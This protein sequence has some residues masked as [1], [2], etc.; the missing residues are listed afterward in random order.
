MQSDWWWLTQCH[1]MTACCSWY[2]PAVLHSLRASPYQQAQCWFASP[3]AHVALPHRYNRC[4]LQAEGAKGP[5]DI[6]ISE[7]YCQ[8]WELL[9]RSDRVQEHM[10]RFR[11]GGRYWSMVHTNVYRRWAVIDFKVDSKE[12]TAEPCKLRVRAHLLLLHTEANT[13]S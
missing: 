6:F 7:P 13:M 10:N 12:V 1:L 2:P 4:V 5:V 9:I 11:P 8:A 3:T